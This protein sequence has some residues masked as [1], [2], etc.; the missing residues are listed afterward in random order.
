MANMC[1]MRVPMK[2]LYTILLLCA[3][4]IISLQ[5]PVQADVVKPALVEI[6]VEANRRVTI[7]VRASIEALLT[8]INAQYKN[9]AD[10]PTAEEYDALRKMTA[11]ALAIE[12]EPF[13]DKFLN[14]VFLQAGQKNLPLSVESVKIP[15][16]GYTKVPRISVIL[17]TTTIPDSATA[18]R[19]YYP[20]AFGDNAVRVRQVDQENERWYWSQWQWLRNDEVSQNFSLT[21][22]VNKQ[23]LFDVFISYVTIGFEHI[24]PKGLDHILFVLGLFL[25]S[26][27][28]KPLLWQVTMFTVAHTITLGLAMNGII[29]LPANVVQPL[30]ALSIAYV[31]I[32]NVY[33]K[34]LHKSRLVLV[35]LFGLLHGLGFA[36]VLADFGMPKDDFAEALI[37]F[38]IGVELGQLAVISMAFILLRLW[39]RD[40]EKYRKIAVVPGS[41]LISI[42]G[43][44]WFLERLELF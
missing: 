13:K 35:F 26:T 28:L 15:P 8:G 21:E 20:A 12:F 32:E 11:D 41:Y 31:G 43:T 39:F 22:I 37:S 29:E 18:V 44:Y 1:N 3:V 23:S 14:S 30:I 2:Q 5:A 34:T 17:L 9:T 16:T 6:N 33:A 24:V 42:I 4:I 10:A 36:S 7:E 40:T 25:L 19:W 38:N 27:R